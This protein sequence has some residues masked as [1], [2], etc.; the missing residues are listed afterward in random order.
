MESA[1]GLARAAMDSGRTRSLEF[2]T[3]A[4]PW[5]LRLCEPAAGGGRRIWAP[6]TGDAVLSIPFPVQVYTAR[7][8][9]DGRQL[10]VAPMNATV[11]ILRA[12]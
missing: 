5:R 3:P 7:F 2:R 1:G 9:P 8:S 11:E 10:A 12:E 6:E 4:G